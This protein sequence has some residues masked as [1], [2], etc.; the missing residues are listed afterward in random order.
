[1]LLDR[2]D[3]SIASRMDRF[4]AM[5]AVTHAIVFM[6]RATG[7][8]RGFGAADSHETERAGQGQRKSVPATL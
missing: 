2:A 6:T 5:L 8:A 7:R 4:E 1:V 3:G